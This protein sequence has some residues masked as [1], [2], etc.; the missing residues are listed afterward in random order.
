MCSGAHVEVWKLVGDGEFD[1][2]GGGEAGAGERGLIDHGAVGP[3]GG[4]DVI[5]FAAEADGVE[6]ALG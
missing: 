1:G 2:G 4:G 5:Y 3:L 6:T